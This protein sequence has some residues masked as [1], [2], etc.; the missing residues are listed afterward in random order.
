M[1]AARQPS[2]NPFRPEDAEEEASRGA[3][4][5]GDDHQPVGCKQVAAGFQER[6]QVGDMFDHLQRKH[7]VEAPRFGAKGAD[8]ADAVFDIQPC[9]VGMGD[10]GLDCA[11]GRVDAGC[12][13]PEAGQRLG[14]QASAASRVQ[15]A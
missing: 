13:R 5:G 7:Q 1:G 6:R 3:V 4:Q 15:H 2:K 11:F 9:G 14:H 12:L 8:T 10:G